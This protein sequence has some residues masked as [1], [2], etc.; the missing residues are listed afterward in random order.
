MPPYPRKLINEGENVVLDLKP[1]WFFFWKH[2]V[3]GHRVPHRV[4]PLGRPRGRL[5]LAGVAAR[6]SGC[7]SWPRSS[8]RS[9]WSGRTRTS[10]SPT[11]GSSHAP[12]S[13]RSA[14]PRSRSSASTTSTSTRTSSCAMIGAGDLDIESA[15]KDGQ[16]HFDNV[17]HPDMVQQEVYRQMEVNARRQASWSGEAAAQAGLGAPTAIPVHESPGHRRPDHEAR[18]AARPGPHHRGRVR[19]EEGRAARAHVRV[20][21]LVPSATE[22][23]LALG[24]VPIACTRFCEQDGIPTVGGTKDPDVDEIVALGAGPGRGERRGEPDRGLQRAAPRPGSTSTRC[25]PGRSATSGRWSRR[26]PARVDAPVPAP[27]A[28]S[29]WHALRAAGRRADFEGRVVVLIWRRPWM[30][31]NGD[32]YGSS[33]LSVLGWRNAV[34]GSRD[35]YPEGEPRA[36]GGLRPRAGAVARRAVPVRR[37]SRRRGR[38][39]LPDRPGRARR[40]ADLFWW[41]SAPRRRWSRLSAAYWW[42]QYRRRHAAH[43]LRRGPRAVPRL[44][45]GLHRQGARAARRGVG[46]GRHRRPR[47]LRQGRARRGSSAWRCPRSTAAG[48][49]PDFR[50]NVVIA[51][52]I[53]RAG[54]NAGGPRLDAAQRHLPA[55]LPD[56]VHRRAEGALAAGDLL[57]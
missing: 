42:R 14:A 40:R 28:G 1:H 23:L 35:R 45:A 3:V 53:Q 26:S 12:A 25:R 37:P 11:G 4:R 48:G 22:T 49:V 13:S 52:E 2:I 17:R 57:G 43:P 54:V 21:S 8:S 6:A 15:G 29:D 56:P 19:G 33:L 20:V 36:A 18:G 31:M 51:E 55:L 41:G 44:G 7:W 46:A 5:Q 16:S 39:G 38:R 9:T 50:Y 32:T 30:T 10:C 24:V 34:S 27:F 47:G